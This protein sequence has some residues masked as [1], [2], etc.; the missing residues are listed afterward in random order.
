M[1]L[2]PLAR[3]PAVCLSAGGCASPPS[4]IPAPN[5]SRGGR[6]GLLRPAVVGIGGAREDGRPRGRSPDSNEP[7]VSWQFVSRCTGHWTPMDS[8]GIEFGCNATSASCTERWRTADL[9]IAPQG[10]ITAGCFG[11]RV[12]PSP[13]L[14]AHHPA[15]ARRCLVSLSVVGSTLDCRRPRMWGRGT[16]PQWGS[17]AGLG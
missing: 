1:S 12:P 2:F 17:G 5:P 11:A 7:V 9:S 3:V 16:A 8:T 6:F 13:R 4:P 15:L 14:E 10:P